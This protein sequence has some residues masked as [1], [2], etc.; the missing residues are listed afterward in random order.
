MGRGEN[1]SLRP[2]QVH[3]SKFRPVN[4]T[5]SSH[6][7]V[8]LHA[9]FC[10]IVVTQSIL[11]ALQMNPPDKL[12]YLPR[13]IAPWKPQIWKL[14]GGSDRRRLKHLLD[15]TKGFKPSKSHSPCNQDRPESSAF[16]QLNQKL[17]ILFNPQLLPE[18][19]SHA[20][21][22]ALDLLLSLHFSFKSTHD[23]PIESSDFHC[24]CPFLILTAFTVCPAVPGHILRLPDL[25][26]SFPFPS[27]SLPPSS[28]HHETPFHLRK[29]WLIWKVQ[30]LNLGRRNSPQH[31][32]FNPTLRFKKGE[33][34]GKWKAFR[35]LSKFRL[36]L[37]GY[38]SYI[39]FHLTLP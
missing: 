18:S 8:Q 20:I 32:N 33:G 26:F 15:P 19:H 1:P 16:S 9:L 24:S 14:S 17:H 36:P 2:I 34:K 3:M 13:H 38:T 28:F 25:L 22:T 23:V 27:S 6:S 21:N 12:P 35:S 31:S 30:L 29:Q 10:L 11:P 37:V 5:T 4:Y 39:S 7:H